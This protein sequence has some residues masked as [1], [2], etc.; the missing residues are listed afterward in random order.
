VYIINPFILVTCAAVVGAAALGATFVSRRDGR[1]ALA[2]LVGAVAGAGGALLAMMPI[3]FCTFEVERGRWDVAIGVTLVTVSSVFLLQLSYWVLDRYTRGLNIIPQAES[4]PG[5]FNGRNAWVSALFCLLPTVG[6]LAVFSYTPMVNT[7]RF[8][9]L[10]A[11][12]GTRRTMF[13]CMDNFTRLITDG[14]YMRILG[15]S[16]FLAVAIVV[17]G[18]SF[19]LLVATMAAQPIKG[20]R[21]YR[22]LLIWPYA[23]SP[24]IAGE[25]FR[26]LFTRE[27]G[28]VNTL[29]G[30]NI[31]WLVDPNMAQWS[32]VIASAW[33]LVG[34][35]ILFYIAGLQNVPDDLLEAA[36]ID[37]ANSIQRFFL[38]TFPLLSPFTFFLV[39][40]NTI[41]ALF[42]TFGMIDVLTQGGPVRSTYTAMYN[43]FKIGIEGQDLGKA[44]AQSLVLLV[45]VIVITVIQFRISRDRI[46]YSV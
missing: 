13:V 4:Q 26:M 32:L 38:I 7:F 20:A 18:L 36:S 43:I 21:I 39:I 44:T 12:F 1:A 34:F 46:T 29:L 31:P 25:L 3:N 42:E 24:I 9:T 23:V 40:T 8:S 16:L 22:T 35:N 14:D 17:S 27:V 5:A 33:N 10:L 11:R 6:L 45:I 15:F 30:L 28:V 41:Y 19:S 2:A 37:G